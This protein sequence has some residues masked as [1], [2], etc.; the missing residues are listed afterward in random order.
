MAMGK[1]IEQPTG[2]KP[3]LHRIEKLVL[4]FPANGTEQGTVTVCGYLDQAAMDQGKRPVVAK[5]HPLDLSIAP[6]EIRDQIK[7]MLYNY[8]TTLPEYQDATQV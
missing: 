7:A 1:E 5:A 4:V 6:A 8:L 2:V 3:S